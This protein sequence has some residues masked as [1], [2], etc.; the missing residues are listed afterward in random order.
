MDKK[1][2][3]LVVDDSAFNRKALVKMLETSEAVRVVGTAIDGEDAIKQAVR[4]NPDVITLDIEMPRMDGFTFLRIMMRNFPT[5]T[6]V[7]S[8]RGEDNIVFKALELG[9][10]DFIAKPTRLV[11]MELFDIERELLN[12]VI[13]AGS[14]NMD[15]VKSIRPEDNE[16]GRAV[17]KKIVRPEPREDF[18]VVV[19]GASTG[20][21]A[22]VQTVLSSLPPG[23]QAAVAV[24]QHMPPGFTR[25]F[26]DRLNRFS[27]MKVREARSGD[28][29][30]PGCVLISPGGFHLTFFKK[31][32]TIRSDLTPG[33]VKDKYIPSIDMLLTSAA[34]LCG[35]RTIGVVMTGM[36]DDGSGGVTSVKAR[37][38]MTIAQSEETSVIFGMPRQAISTGKVDMVVPLEEI[39]DGIV[40]LCGSEY[41]Y[42]GADA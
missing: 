11:S 26:A 39:A 37:G 12:K 8:S 14:A 27:H 19:I 28:P 30:R 20:G 32:D 41:E 21:P 5:P 9:A 42:G 15:V 17:Y 16:I 34:E 24:S 25:S 13:T 33:S 22:A 23:L 36:G 18:A 1:I 4:L 10:V 3:V 6:V 29:L 38:G 40:S 31:G 7:I 2:N 35:A